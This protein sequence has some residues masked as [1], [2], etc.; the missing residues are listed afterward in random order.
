MF[1]LFASEAVMPRKLRRNDRV[2]CAIEGKVTGRHG[3]VR[4]IVENLSAGGLFFAGRHLPAGERIEIQFTL[5][6]EPIQAT[7][8]VLYRQSHGEGAGIGVR[9]LR[10]S[11][12]G[13]ECIQRYLAQHQYS[14]SVSTGSDTDSDS[15]PK[16]EPH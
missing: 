8:E 9:F 11:P 12:G 4:G 5:D 7:V 16:P 3:S 1:P 6:D 13:V 15:D 2:P 10:L 14:S